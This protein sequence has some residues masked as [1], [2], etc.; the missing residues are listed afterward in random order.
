MILDVNTQSFFRNHRDDH[1][2]ITELAQAVN[3]Y[4][5]SGAPLLTDSPR[6]VTY[7]LM[8][9]AMNRL[10]GK[11]F[12]Q[13]EDPRWEPILC[14]AIGFSFWWSGNMDRP[15]PSTST[16]YRTI[17]TFFTDLENEDIAFAARV[18]RLT[19]NEV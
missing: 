15:D 7:L 12:S 1:R 6:L 18:R 17:Y 11:V 16:E 10:L 19:E 14:E 3:D 9:H 8:L 5:Y 4:A 13:C 2:F